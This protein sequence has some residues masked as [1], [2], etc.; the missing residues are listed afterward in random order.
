[1]GQSARGESAGR[2]L[3]ISGDAHHGS[4]RAARGANKPSIILVDPRPLTRESVVHLLTTGARDF[5]VVP[6]SSSEELGSVA[7]DNAGVVILNIGYALVTDEWVSREVRAI[8]AHMPTTPLIVLCDSEDM[9]QVVMAL[10]QGIRG[11]IPTTFSPQVAVEA[12]R[13]VHAGGTFIPASALQDRS[14]L[15]R[16]DTI[17]PD[18]WE[19]AH[20]EEKAVGEHDA[21]AAVFRAL[22]PRQRQVLRLLCEGQPN[23][24]IAYA[25]SMQEGTVKVHVRQIMK[26]LKVTNRTQVAFLANRLSVEVSDD[27]A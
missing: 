24:N 14:D 5:A 9:G 19:V 2:L 10:S 26:K 7:V 13:L 11:Y 17:T 25:L 20:V 27:D 1:M 15:G 12:I 8:T 16:V 3:A 18:H 6:V 23:K 4:L 21:Q 22:T